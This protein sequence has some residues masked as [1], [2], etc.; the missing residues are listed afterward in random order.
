M[1]LAIMLGVIGVVTA[2]VMPALL[3]KQ[4]GHCGARSL[5]DAAT[6]RKCDAPF[7]EDETEED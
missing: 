4:C 3:T 1:Y 2:L 7:P 5:L 6:C